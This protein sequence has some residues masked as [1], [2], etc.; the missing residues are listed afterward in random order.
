LVQALKDKITVDRPNVVVLPVRGN[1]K[2]LLKLTREELDSLR[3]PFIRAL[4]Y[5][6]FNAPN[7][8]GL[9]V[10]E[11][12]SW[13]TMNFNDQ[14]VVVRLNG[15]NRDSAPRQWLCHWEEK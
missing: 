10:F 14:P 11:D 12:R 3:A 15:K 7:R 2:S 6:E 13:V 8:V 9:I 5:Q 1:P 4:G